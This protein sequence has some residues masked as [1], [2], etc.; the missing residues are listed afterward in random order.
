MPRCGFVSICAFVVA[1]TPLIGA[2]GPASKPGTAIPRTPWGHPD[3][4]GRWTNATVTPLERPTE[5]GAKEYFTSEE[6]SEYQKHALER[7]LAS[8]N[9]T[10]EAAISGEF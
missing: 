4:Q 7:F 1:L 5:L 3:L 6:A 8:I 2:Q 10:E 9:F